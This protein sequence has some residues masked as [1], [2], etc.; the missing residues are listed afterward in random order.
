[1]TGNCWE[2]T[3]DWYQEHARA[4]GNCCSMSNPRGGMRDTSVNAS[5]EVAIPRKVMKGGSY[6]CAPNY[7][8][9]YRPAT[10]WPR[11]SIPRLVTWA[12]AA[13]YG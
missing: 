3:S 13:S 4:G 8:H 12:F 2:W 11:Q 1:M 10:G 7:C 5:D 9:R 6:L